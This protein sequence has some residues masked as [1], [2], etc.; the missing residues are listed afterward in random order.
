MAREVQLER[1]LDIRRTLGN[2]EFMPQYQQRPGAEEGVMFKA[3]WLKRC[4]LPRPLETDH[5]EKMNKVIVV[6]PGGSKK[7][8]DYTAMWVFGLSPSQDY[9]LLDGVRDKLTLHQRAEALLELAM[10]WHPITKCLYESYGLQADIEHIEYVQARKNRYFWIQSIGGKVS[11]PERIRALE[12]LFRTGRLKLPKVLPYCPLADDLPGEVD[13]IRQFV[14]GGVQG[15]PVGAARRHVGR[16]GAA[17]GPSSGF[18]LA[19][20]GGAGEGATG[21]RE[22]AQLARK[23]SAS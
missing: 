16:D 1:L 15:I 17:G 13:L 12:P 4:Y 19:G 21:A 6:D 2:E 20:G 14:E 7:K 18:G 11:K 5:I 8:S 9:F 23:E 3:E 22:R 10:R